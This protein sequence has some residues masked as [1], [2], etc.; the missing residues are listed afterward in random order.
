MLMNW[1][2]I[3]IFSQQPICLWEP[4]Q[5]VCSLWMDLRCIGAPKAKRKKEANESLN[6]T[7]G[8]ALFALEMVFGR[9]W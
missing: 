3:T 2:V 7:E 5:Q 4:S 6:K 8:A 9:Q 1:A